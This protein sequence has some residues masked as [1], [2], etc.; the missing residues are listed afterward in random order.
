MNDNMI[1]INPSVILH[2][3]GPLRWKSQINGIPKLQG[4]F[5]MRDQEG[6][7][8]DMIYEIA[9]EN[10]WDVDWV[11]ALADAARQSVFK[12]DALIEELK[13]LLSQ[14]DVQR[15]EWLFGVGF[16]KQPG[17]TFKEKTTLLYNEMRNSHKSTEKL[18]ISD[19][20][21][22]FSETGVFEFPEIKKLIKNFR[23]NKHN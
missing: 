4:V 13:M 6:F 12:Y 3:S 18:I 15:I 9:K 14:D 8:L 17:E 1:T 11:E 23:Q 20:H 10:N 19:N 22:F 5:K 21:I 2:E 7:P 16:M